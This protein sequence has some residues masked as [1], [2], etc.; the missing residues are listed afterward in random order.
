MKKQSKVS[1]TSH[2]DTL[3]RTLLPCRDQESSKKAA[4]TLKNIRIREESQSHLCSK[5]PR[6][7]HMARAGGNVAHSSVSETWTVKVALDENR[8]AM[9]QPN[10]R[11]KKLLE[12]TAVLIEA[13]G[14]ETVKRGVVHPFLKVARVE[15]DENIRDDIAH[16]LFKNCADPKKRFGQFLCSIGVRSKTKR[17]R[18]TWT[19]DP[20][21]YNRVGYRI[22]PGGDRQGGKPFILFV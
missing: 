11:Y 12:D 19:F 16:V 5:T 8:L 3:S 10:P 7:T 20:E 1:K 6:F 21:A 22:T 14:D 9:W 18:V 2:I 13:L 17:K 15:F 4:S